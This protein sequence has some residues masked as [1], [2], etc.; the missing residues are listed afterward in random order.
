MGTMQR[1]TPEKGNIAKSEQ[2]KEEN[3]SGLV[4]FLLCLES[5]CFV[6]LLKM[7]LF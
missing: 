3:A 1:G 4:I 2:R 6:G 5:L 7:L